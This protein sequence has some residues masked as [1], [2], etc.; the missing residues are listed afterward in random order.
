MSDTVTAPLDC[1][2]V[3]ARLYP[4]LDRELDASEQAAV[5][6]HLD[7][8]GNC[9]GLFRLEANMLIYVGRRLAA[10]EAPAALR[11]RLRRFCLPGRA[12]E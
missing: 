6:A 8:C 3:V 9:A 11:A 7:K 12:D 4:Y 1:A 10:V 2:E 5:Q